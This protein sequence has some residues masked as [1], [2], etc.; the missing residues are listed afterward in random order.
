MR[1]IDDLHTH[2]KQDL[3]NKLFKYISLSRNFVIEVYH[4]LFLHQKLKFEIT[5]ISFKSRLEERNDKDYGMNQKNVLLFEDKQIFLFL[6]LR[7]RKILSLGE[8]DELK[9]HPFLVH[10]SDLFLSKITDL[11]AEI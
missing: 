11:C 10:F 4:A 5:V 1:R 3:I 7:T 9:S 8:F 6:Y 2:T